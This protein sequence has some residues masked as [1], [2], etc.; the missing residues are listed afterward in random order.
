MQS[1]TDKEVQP[2][3]VASS[4]R[5]DFSLSQKQTSVCLCPQENVIIKLVV[6][7]K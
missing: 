2:Q 4:V 5:P 1:T 3:Y 6:N 7:L